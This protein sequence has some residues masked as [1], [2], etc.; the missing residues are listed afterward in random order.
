MV[1]DSSETLTIY[2]VDLKHIALVLAKEY[3]LLYD[4]L[5]NGFDLPIL[6]YKN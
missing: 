3:C 6:Y 1:T 4:S 5:N 2:L